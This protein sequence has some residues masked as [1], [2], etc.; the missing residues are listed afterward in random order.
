MNTN[1]EYLFEIL[2]KLKIKSNSKKYVIYNI[3]F[4]L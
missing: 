2:K 1:Y 3:I 4:K